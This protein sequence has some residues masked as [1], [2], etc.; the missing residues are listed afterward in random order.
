MSTT[1]QT[2]NFME[3]KDKLYFEY[4]G[5]YR[6]LVADLNN[7]DNNWRRKLVRILQENG[8]E[9][10]DPVYTQKERKILMLPIRIKCI[11]ETLDKELCLRKINF[12]DGSIAYF[13]MFLV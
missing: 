9:F 1:G 6:S 12:D 5:Y 3:M 7:F 13:D 2:A 10:P 8:K 4:S 11:D